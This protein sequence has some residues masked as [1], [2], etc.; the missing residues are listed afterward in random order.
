M[1]QPAAVVQPQPPR[2]VSSRPVRPR[3][4]RRRMTM[5][6]RNNLLAYGL[7]APSVVVALA[8]I[9]YPLFVIVNLSFRDGNTMI[10]SEIG[11]LPLT[12]GNYTGVL[13]NPDTWQSFR[14]SAIYTAATVTG[15]IVIGMATALLLRHDMPGRRW[16]R[17]MMLIPWPI[18]GAIATVAFVWMLDG[19]YGVVNYLLRAV[20]IL[21]ENVAWFFN[22][23]TALIG[24]L[25]PTIWIAYPMCTLM[26]LA[27]LQSV[28]DELYEAAKMDGANPFKQFRYI[29][30]PAIQNTSVLAMVITGLWSFTTFDFIYAITRGGP[31]RATETLAVAIYNEAFQFFHLP[32]ASAL[33][34][35]T[36]VIA[37]IVLVALFPI[38]RK[39]FF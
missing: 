29:T 25:M 31:N 6:R 3:L 4:P 39:R 36:M 12:I 18:P 24:V 5:S 30:W 33:G 7:L 28:P 2:S 21:Q 17:T 35:V 26:I 13:T 20:G 32:Y 16:L 9:A 19:T 11:D 27:A 1:S 8:F 37:G 15:A 14:I 23:E 22:P 34:V 10:L 38:L